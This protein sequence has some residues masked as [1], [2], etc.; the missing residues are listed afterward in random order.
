MMTKKVVTFKIRSVDRQ[1]ILRAVKEKYYLSISEF[2]RS[3]T[4]HLLETE[5]TD[6]TYLEK[7]VMNETGERGTGRKQRAMT[8]AAFRITEIELRAV[9]YLVKK[10]IFPSYSK[11]YRKAA[12]DEIELYK[13]R[14]T[15]DD[16]RFLQ[17]V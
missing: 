3:G 14:K 9:N 5:V 17:D 7:L 6:M 11:L 10:G 13:R 2:L 15:L 8:H 4:R 12:H 16:K 1:T